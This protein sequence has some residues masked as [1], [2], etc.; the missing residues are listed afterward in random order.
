M[1]WLA[2]ILWLLL[3]VIYFSIW[4]CSK[5][6]CCTATMNKT[7]SEPKGATQLVSK[8][9][10]GNIYFHSNS[11]SASFG[12]HWGTYADSLGK[13]E[14][15]NK[16]LTITG[17]YNS[18]EI[19]H[20]TYA[21]LGLARAEM[22]KTELVKRGVIA[23][24]NTNSKLIDSDLIS[25]SLYVLTSAILALPIVEE[26]DNKAIIHHEFNSTDWDKSPELIS[27]LDKVAARAIEEKFKIDLKG[28]T[29]NVGDDQENKKLGLN[30]AIT[31]KQYLV[32]KGVVA[33]SIS[34]ESFGESQP[35][36]SNDTEDGRALNRRTEL[37]IKK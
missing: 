6:S 33:K 25:D 23:T 27:Y 34:V 14:K 9:L 18:K 32:S 13:I 2:F 29:D 15:G 30:R 7:D 22:M 1:R 36:A 10:P 3:G 8:A 37:I 20:T 12:T 24:Y 35:I 26:L 16:E 31:I 21:N 17:F 19:N 5:E 11:D 4:S 28:H